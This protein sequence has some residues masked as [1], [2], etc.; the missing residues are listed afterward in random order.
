[1]SDFEENPDEFIVEKVLR[2]R[3]RNGK[4]EYF[5]KWKGYPDSENTWEPE[6]NLD[7]PD[8]IKQFEENAKKLVNKPRPVGKPSSIASSDNGSVREAEVPKTESAPSSDPDSSKTVDTASKKR[9]RKR[10]NATSQESDANK[11]GDEHEEEEEGEDEEE[12][13]GGSPAK[14]SPLPFGLVFTLTGLLDFTFNSV[15]YCQNYPQSVGKFV[16][17]NVTSR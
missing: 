14:V 3:I 2:V 4:K 15:R 7:C 17:L 8:L 10:R 13:E 1:M 5:L 9:G 11:T 6:E 16:V 12:G